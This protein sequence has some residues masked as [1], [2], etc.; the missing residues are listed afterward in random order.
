MSRDS[1]SEIVAQTAYNLEHR[2]FETEMTSCELKAPSYLRFDFFL[3]TLLI[4]AKV[5]KN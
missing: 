2:L 3:L 4:M 5:I 1:F